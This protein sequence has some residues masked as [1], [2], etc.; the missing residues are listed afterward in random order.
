MSQER[1]ARWP[2]RPVLRP[3]VHVAAGAQSRLLA[4]RAQWRGAELLL[5]MGG[6]VKPRHLSPV[7]GPLSGSPAH[8]L[9]RCPRAVFRCTLLAR[10]VCPTNLLKSQS[11]W[12]ILKSENCGWALWC[13]SAATEPTFQGTPVWTDAASTGADVLE[14]L[15]AAARSPAGQRGPAWSSR[16]SAAPPGVQRP[17]LLVE[18]GVGGEGHWAD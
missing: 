10:D 16:D 12:H 1:S 11:R 6:P 17:P 4:D 18:A 9:P 15:W 8:P 14:R 2:G 5:G 3:I 7:L 13:H